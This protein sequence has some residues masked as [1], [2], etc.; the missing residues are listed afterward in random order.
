MKTNTEEGL[1]DLALLHL[2]S[3]KVPQ[4]IAHLE[5]AAGRPATAM[6]ALTDLSAAYLARFE[7]EG[8]LQDLLRS[9]QA[10]D[11]GLALA[12]AQP[13]L[14][15]NRALAFSTLGTPRIGAKAW[16]P[17]VD[18]PTPSGWREEAVAHLRKLSGPS[19]EEEW[20]R[21]LPEIEAPAA[22]LQQI[23]TRVER[24]P[25]NARS[26]AEE[27]LLPRWAAA[28][29]RSDLAVA[30]RSLR[31]ATIIG[32]VLERSHG[33]TLLTDALVSVQRTMEHGSPDQ[34]RAL[35]QGLQDFGPGVVHYNEQNLASARKLLVRAQDNLA[36]VDC[37]L[38]FWAR[39]YLAI[40][41]YYVD[42]DR[43]LAEYKALLAEIPQNRYPALTGRLEWLAGTADKVQG[44]IQS[45]VRRYTH[46]AAALR[47]SG[48]PEA[49]FVS[50][51]LAESYSL[52]GE[53]SL[54]WQ[55]RRLAF[56]RVCFSEGPR[57]NIAMWT[58]AKEALLRQGRLDLAGPFVDE[59]VA[60]AARW[61]RP[62]GQ[63]SAHVERA[64]YRLEIGARPAALADLREVQQALSQMEESGLKKQMASIVLLTEGLYEQATDPARAASL[65][66]QALDEQSVSGN[67][68]EAITY[69]TAKATAQ[70][71]AGDLQESAA[72]LEG[73]LSIFEAIRATVEDPVSRMQAF[74]QAQPAFDH[75]IRLRTG[76][77]AG[78]REE[79]FRLSERARARVLL[80]LRTRT[81]APAP[82]RQEFARLTDLEK[83]LP[84]GVALASY[85]VL[86]DQTLA[87]VVENGR[88]RLQVLPIHRGDLASTIETLRLEMTRGAAESAIQNAATP[89]YDALVRPL[90]LAPDREGS[91]II[92]PDRWLTRL[93]FAAL[94]DRQS[95]QYLIEQRTVTMVP[96]ATLLLRGSRARRPLAAAKLSALVLGVS[97][98]GL[99]GGKVLHSL[100]HAEEEA[101]DVA[102]LYQQPT[103]LVGAAA[104]KANF[105]RMSVSQDV[106]HF[107]G[108]AIVDLESPRRSVLLFA[109]S[110]PDAL[111]PL[112][113]GELFDAGL[114]HA[115]L[116]VLSACRAQDSLVDDREG[117]LG[118]AG[119]FFAAGVP[120]VVASPWDV[121]DR[122]AVPVM[123]AFHRAY[124]K[125]RSAG[126]AFRQAVLELLR[127]GNP[128]QRSPAS[129]GGFTVIAGDLDNGGV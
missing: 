93:P 69:T 48:G 7:T 99:F 63:V 47:R 97:R 67:R 105:L 107:A 14:L 91:L 66:Q 85:A 33:E 40:D 114:G 100:P 9:V 42:A 56:Q 34:R 90:G 81:D 22:D 18:D 68:F 117:L 41:K 64:A 123:V 122:S 36:A 111:E 129:W 44:R 32:E 45:S 50:V 11:R 110:A 31:L 57:R 27:V 108:H 82:K 1:L 106:M 58:E 43:G 80:E 60:E 115:H 3:G 5:L 119:A 49:A 128:E 39:L 12:P 96:S 74:R 95:G 61:G 17:F 29:S 86:E 55:Q 87:W 65:L 112:S 75:L 35:L 26:Y 15:F 28:V 71:A 94:F 16:R 102:A 13:S 59:A 37:P 21:L 103:A 2:L 51:L 4:A 24:L 6:A 25:A 124:Q 38:S 118:I 121:N 76:V 113:L 127:S 89:L 101:R 120:E 78:D 116:V 20:Q 19:A 88:A 92:V 53:H 126:V 104:S 79:P 125:H 84:A 54:G 73:A 109:G 62:L 52:L 70:L 23:T 8:D 77:L 30:E 83:L 72:S 98:P 10:A 46:A